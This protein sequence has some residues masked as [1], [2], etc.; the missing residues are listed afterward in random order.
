MFI[1]FNYCLSFGICP[2]KLKLAKVIFVYK[3]GSCD[4][5]NNYRP[6]SLL[7]SLSKVFERLMHTVI[8][9]Y[10]VLHVITLLFQPNMVLNTNIPQYKLLET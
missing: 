1:I 5:L 3:K 9:F 2:D 4:Q 6:I 8:V 10:H 7:S